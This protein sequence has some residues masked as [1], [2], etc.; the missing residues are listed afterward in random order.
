MIWA[1]S[2]LYY[3]EKT[4]I[5]MVGE[6]VSLQCDKE[7]HVGEPKLVHCGRIEGLAPLE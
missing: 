1:F 5:M 6:R 3:Y 7:S 2:V 4:Y